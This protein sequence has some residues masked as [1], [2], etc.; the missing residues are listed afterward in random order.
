MA[1]DDS[2]DE[3]NEPEVAFTKKK[4]A[5][6]WE[7]DDSSDEEEKHKVVASKP[8]NE[9]KN[10]KKIVDKRKGGNSSAVVDE[11]CLDPAEEKLRRQKLIEDGDLE[12]TMDLF[13]A[14]PEDD[15]PGSASN[16]KTKVEFEAFAEIL[17]KRL[18]GH[19]G[20]SHFQHCVKELLRHALE[21]SDS[22][23][24]KGIGTF[25]NTKSSEVAKKEKE[26]AQKGKKKNS[27]KQLGH[28]R[29]GGDDFMDAGLGHGGDYDAVGFDDG[30]FM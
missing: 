2:S 22:Q 13:G 20:S 3:D 1:W 16:P 6:S 18:Q 15:T 11:P 5:T 12:V 19:A 17:G 28:V 14:A 25:C 4:P 8:K 10:E 27:K 29:G 24:I 26:E 7:D 30:D 23:T 21:G 9:K